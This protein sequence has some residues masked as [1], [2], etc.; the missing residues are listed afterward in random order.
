MT[1]ILYIST[2][3]SPGIFDKI[4]LSSKIKPGQAVQKF[5]RLLIEGFCLNSHSCTLDV[6]S[7][8]P[9]TTQSHSKKWW[10]IQREKFKGASII[11]IPFL[12]FFLFKYLF[13]FITTFYRVLSWRIKNRGMKRIVIC[14]I[15]NNGIVWSTFIACKL[16]RQK[17][18]VLVTD[19]PEM[20]IEANKKTNL[21][22]KIIVTLSMYVLHRFDYYV[23]LTQQMNAVVNPNRKPFIVMEGLVD[24]NMRK[25]EDVIKDSKRVIL[26]AGAL[27]EKYGVKNLLE[28]FTKINDNSIELHLY[29]GGDMSAFLPKYQEHDHRI[30]YFGEVSNSIIVSKLSKSTLLINPRPTHEDFTKYSFPSKNIEY[31]VSG[32][33]LLCTNLPGMPSEYH[34]Y[35]YILPDDSVENLS[36]KIQEILS[37]DTNELLSFGT[38]AK[39]FVLRE[40]NNIKQTKRIISLINGN[41]S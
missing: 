13:V 23:I 30:K 21:I 32:T 28:A 10:Y 20:M 26:Y 34:D 22:N 24:T 39:E 36:F 41:L 1:K 2:F 4:F 18:L 3:C 8:I 33:P 16:T 40:K 35:V 19:L 5:H 27:F 17:M 25:V 29:G 9:V 14:D 31:M 6:L 12:N 7:A 37:L 15:L 38:K 11:Y